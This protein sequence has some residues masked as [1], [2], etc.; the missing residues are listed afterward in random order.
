M[1]VKDSKSST[2]HGVDEDL[3]RWR[4]PLSKLFTLPEMRVTTQVEPVSEKCRSLIF[5]HSALALDLFWN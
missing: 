2:L 1:R 5:V 3:G 4:F